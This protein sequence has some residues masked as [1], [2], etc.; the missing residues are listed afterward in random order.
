MGNEI[1]SDN[2]ED[3]NLPGESLT[4][5]ESFAWR[6]V[7]TP[8]KFAHVA[9]S[10]YV[11]VCCD[12]NGMVWKLDDQLLHSKTWLK[13]PGTCL[14]APFVLI[15]LEFDVGFVTQV[16]VRSNPSGDAVSGL[17]SSPSSGL[18]SQVQES[19]R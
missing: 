8:E 2:D 18:T 12:V 5:I 14:L 3:D 7:S 6:F 4:A 17:L 10:E 9:C 11:V 19:L 13:L 15:L 1:S 16:A